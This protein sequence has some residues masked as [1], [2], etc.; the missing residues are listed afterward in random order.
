[1]QAYHIQK[2]SYI[3]KIIYTCDVCIRLFPSLYTLYTG[4][5]IHTTLVCIKYTTY[6]I[7]PINQPRPTFRPCPNFQALILGHALISGQATFE[8]TP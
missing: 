4:V 2:Q 1:M 5:Q 8:A 3:H 7:R 6:H